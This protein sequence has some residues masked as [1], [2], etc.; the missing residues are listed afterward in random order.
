MSKHSNEPE[1]ITNDRKSIHITIPSK[2]WKT[3]S[4]C[5]MIVAAISF[6]VAGGDQS[7]LAGWCILGAFVALWD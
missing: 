5:A 7:Y 1:E 3:I 4:A 2:G 6:A